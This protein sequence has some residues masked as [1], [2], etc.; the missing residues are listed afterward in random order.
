MRGS[1]LPSVTYLFILLFLEIARVW[2][3]EILKLLRFVRSQC[4]WVEWIQWHAVFF[5]FRRTEHLYYEHEIL[6]PWIF[7]SWKI[8]LWG[9][10]IELNVLSTMTNLLYYIFPENHSL[11][12]WNRHS[13]EYARAAA[14]DGN[15]DE[16]N[17][18]RHFIKCDPLFASIGA[19]IVLLIL[20]PPTI[21]CKCA[22]R[23][24][25][26]TISNI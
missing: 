2:H 12:I 19:G 3:T 7:Q 17:Y 11:F 26:R 20:S 15:A 24:R 9:A 6:L 23:T 14:S 5:F 4:D 8:R 18:T 21:A 22:C 13:S 25:H 1:C 10:A 16:F